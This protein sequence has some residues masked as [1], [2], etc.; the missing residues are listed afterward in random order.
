MPNEPAESDQIQNQGRGV[1][2]PERGG[3]VGVPDH[4]QS[5]P[6]DLEGNT[7]ANSDQLV[8]AT[9]LQSNWLQILEGD[10]DTT[11]SGSITRTES[12]GPDSRELLGVAASRKDGALR[13]HRHGGW[14]GVRRA[15]HGW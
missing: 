12:R 10:I 5:R 13:N 4:A 8:C 7:Q 2:N 14:R 1:S 6:F 3:I 15:A 9:Q 11:T